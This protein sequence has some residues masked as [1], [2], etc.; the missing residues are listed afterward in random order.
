MLLNSSWRLWPAKN[1]P[2]WWPCTL[3][4]KKRDCQVLERRKDT[5][6]PN[7]A[8]LPDVIRRPKQEMKR[9]WLCHYVIWCDVMPYIHIALKSRLP[10]HLQSSG[11]PPALPVRCFKECC[12][13]VFEPGQSC[14]MNGQRRWDWGLVGCKT[15]STFYQQE[16]TSLS[17]WSFLMRYVRHCASRPALCSVP[18]EWPLLLPSQKPGLHPWHLPFTDRSEISHRASLP[19]AQCSFDFSI[20]PVCFLAQIL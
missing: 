8:F 3:F 14:W 19:K 7:W 16:I 12:L 9:K 13:G 4:V 2:G 5:L 6:T 20:L 18:N 11:I 17:D 10:C 15:A 1:A